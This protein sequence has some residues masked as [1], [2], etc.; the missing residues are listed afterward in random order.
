MQL[1]YMCSRKITEYGLIAQLGARLIQKHSPIFFCHNT[2]NWRSWD[3][4]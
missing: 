3:R 1:K 4:A 2:G